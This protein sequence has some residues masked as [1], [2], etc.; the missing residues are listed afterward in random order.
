MEVTAEMR[1]A[2]AAREKMEE[3]AMFGPAIPDQLLQ[4]QAALIDSTKRVK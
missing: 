3:A 1:E 2:E 4:K